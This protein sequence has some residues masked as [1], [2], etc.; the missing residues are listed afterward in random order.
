MF[1]VGTEYTRAEIHGQVGGGVQPYLP[2]KGGKVVAACITK[3]LNPRAPQVILCG[4]GARIEPTGAVLAAQRDPVPVFIK[5][6]VNRW[7]LEGWFLAVA[8]HTSGQR[9]ESLMANSG[10][11]SSDVSLAVELERVPH[12]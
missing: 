4:K 6:G 9:F 2:T 3:K 10:R 5:R 12:A 1:N 8:S 11:E 7:E